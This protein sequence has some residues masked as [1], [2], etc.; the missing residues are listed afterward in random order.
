LAHLSES[1]EVGEVEL[2]FSEKHRPDSAVEVTGRRVVS[3][4]D[5]Y[6]R[7]RARVVTWAMNE[8][9]VNL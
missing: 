8:R 9:W 7:R 6:S 2:F 5:F 3:P 4:I 1:E